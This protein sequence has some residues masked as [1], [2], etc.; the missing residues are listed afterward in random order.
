MLIKDENHGKL[1]LGINLISVLG[2]ELLTP[3]PVL[4][5]GVVVM[6]EDGI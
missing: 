6:S 2:S 5:C 3:S 4:A 1:F